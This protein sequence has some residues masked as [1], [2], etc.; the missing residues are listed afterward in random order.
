VGVAAGGWAEKSFCL[1]VSAVPSCAQDSF[2]INIFVFLLEATITQNMK[3]TLTERRQMSLCIHVCVCVCISW[4]GETVCVC[5]CVAVGKTTR[6]AA[7]SKSNYSYATLANV[8]ATLAL[9][10]L[11][12]LLPPDTQSVPPVF[13]V[14]VKS[15]RAINH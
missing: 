7:A 12:F 15:Y 11:L 8:A 1:P 2:E 3:H 10:P 6:G 9:L 4:E 14:D 5:V 13:R